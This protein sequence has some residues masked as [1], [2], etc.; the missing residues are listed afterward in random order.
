MANNQY[1]N[2]VIYGENTL[3]DLSS[4]TVTADKIL[5]G[6]TAHSAAGATITGS[7]PTKTGNDIILQNTILTI[8]AGYYTNEA[9][10][11]TGVE[12]TIPSS[13]TNSFDVTMPSGENNTITLTFEVDSEGNSNVTDDSTG[14]ETLTAAEG[15]SF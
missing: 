12:L 6:Y 1:V 4:D 9:K 3:I 15:V 13:G 11:I 5:A 14:G 7:I 10:T 2:K 8:P